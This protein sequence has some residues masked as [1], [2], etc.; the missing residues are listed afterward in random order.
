MAFDG[1]GNWI[2]EFSAKEDRDAGVKIL[3][4]RFDDVFQ[5]DLKNS[6]EKC[7]TNDSQNRPLQD[8]NFNNNKGINVANPEKLGDVV[9]LKIIDLIYPVGS[10]YIGTQS[11]CPLASILSD[12]TWE[13]VAQ[14][15]ALWGGDGTNGNTTIEAGL[16]N[17]TGT[18]TSRGIEHTK[19]ETS[20]AFYDA[21]TSNSGSGGDEYRSGR[22]GFDASKANPIYGGSST[23][24]PPAYRVNVWRRTK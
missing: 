4:D 11:S 24:Q 1:N 17:I 10:I 16:P 12:S 3:A 9:N 14:D 7:L 15:R 22:I 8:F 2:P 20:G 19:I 18:Y 21:G 5:Q 13:L 6:F 23:V